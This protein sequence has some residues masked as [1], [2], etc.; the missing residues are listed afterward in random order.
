MNITTKTTFDNKPLSVLNDL[1]KR[2]S[3]VLRECC[4]DAVS[5]TMID[6]L[7]S[8]RAATGNAIKTKKFVVKVEDTG[9][10]GGYS[11]SE[12]KPVIRNGVSP[13]STKLDV[14]GKVVWQTFGTKRQSQK[15]VYKVTGEDG[16]P[17]YVV[18]PTQQVAEDYELRCIKH[19]IEH[20]GG[21]AKNAL[22]VAMHA[23]ASKTSKYD[24]STQS[25]QEATQLA[26]VIT[27]DTGNNFS[28]HVEDNL[29]YATEALKGGESAINIALMKASN[30]VASVID[31][32]ASKGLTEPVGT[33]F[34]E[35]RKRK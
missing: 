4:R 16:V 21:L 27:N 28:V 24:G 2:R 31:R 15:H 34:P 1:I 3:E 30:K 8:I 25:I 32:T 5:A 29:D 19:R 33:P 14:S 35:V 9:W 23:I 22:G 20:H 26:N 17:Y 7:V 13:Y 12:R 10:Y 18:A 11:F 6:V